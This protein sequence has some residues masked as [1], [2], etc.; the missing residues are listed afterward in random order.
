MCPF[1]FGQPKS[2]SKFL[3]LENTFTLVVLEQ[4]PACGD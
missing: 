1:L 2:I 4:E 3:S